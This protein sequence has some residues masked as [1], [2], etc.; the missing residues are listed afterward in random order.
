M[1]A[2]LKNKRVKKK[3]KEKKNR[4]EDKG[5]NIEKELGVILKDLPISLSLNPSLMHKEEFLLK[6]FENQMG[7]NLELFKVNPLEFENSNLRKEAFEQN[8]EANEVNH[9]EFGMTRSV[10]DPRGWIKILSIR[11]MFFPTQP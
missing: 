6:D 3:N 2:S 11:M 10:F 7:F 4:I 5:R 9:K 1:S 8:H